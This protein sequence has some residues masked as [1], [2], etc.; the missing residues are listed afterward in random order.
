MNSAV[1]ASNRCVGP[2]GATATA[3]RNDPG[4]PF[5]ALDV[6]Q[7]AFAVDR[8]DLQAYDLADAQARCIGGRQRN[9]IAQSFDRRQETHHLLSAQHRWELLW[10]L[11]GN[12]PFEC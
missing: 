8:A 7:H 3:S 5:A 10:F 4:P 12:D 2:P 6:Q 11:A 1:P 9:T